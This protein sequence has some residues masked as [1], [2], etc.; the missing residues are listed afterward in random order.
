LAL[1]D[2][3]LLVA[4]LGCVTLVAALKLLGLVAAWYWLCSGDGAQGACAQ[5]QNCH[6]ERRYA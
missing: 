4:H 1:L 3:A 2:L 5:N 6:S